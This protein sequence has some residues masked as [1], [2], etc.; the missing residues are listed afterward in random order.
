LNT[1]FPFIK[2]GQGETPQ[3]EQPAERSKK[4]QAKMYPQHKSTAELIFY[5]N[6]LATQSQPCERRQAALRAPS[7]TMEEIRVV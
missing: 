7:E 5:F 6:P 3:S 2:R 4:S 1:D